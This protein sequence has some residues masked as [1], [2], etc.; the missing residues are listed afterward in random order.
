MQKRRR[1]HSTI[2]GERPEMLFSLAQERSKG[3]SRTQCLVVWRF[4]IPLRSH[5]PAL[6]WLGRGMDRH[7][8]HST[9]IGTNSDKKGGGS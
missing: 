1:F 6:G 4:Q 8:Y 7:F 5:C 3:V 2:T 9:V